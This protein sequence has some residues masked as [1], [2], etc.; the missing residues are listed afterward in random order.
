MYGMGD[1]VSYGTEIYETYH[2]WHNER[3]FK[4]S[5]RMLINEGI[6]GITF[7]N[8]PDHPVPWARQVINDMNVQDRV[9]LIVDIHDLDSIRR[10]FIPKPEREMFNSAD[11]L[12]Y[13]SKPIQEMT[14]KL[15]DVSK[16]NISLFSYCNENLVEYDESKIHER[17]GLVYEGG[18]NPPNDDE[19]NRIFEYR[20]LYGIIKRLVELGNE[21]HMYCGNI[22]AYDTY[23]NI[24]AVV[25]PPTMYDK[26]MKELIKYKYGVLI[27]N[28]ADGKKDQ[29]NYTLSNKM[30]EYLHAGLPNIAC[31][32]PES[33]K[34]I[35]KHGIGFTFKHIDEIGNC[36]QLENKYL[37]IMSNINIK[38][39]ELIMERFIWRLENLYAEVLGLDRKSIPDDIKESSIFEYGKEDTEKLIS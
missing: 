17:K 15:Q 33:E 27:F 12:I 5:I 13:V 7:N 31:W 6:D 3:Q 39:K 18:A 10:G 21:T 30:Q 24:G 34:Y 4:E 26:L 11:G 16:P 23:Q 1:K 29:V 37:E 9:K 35:D 22:S 36:S 25:H 14:N 8:E 19:L 20:S 28:N 2:I 32:C 38:K